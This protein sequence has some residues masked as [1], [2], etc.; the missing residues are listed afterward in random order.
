MTIEFIT[1]LLPY[2]SGMTLR[3]FDEDIDSRKREGRSF[4]MD[5]DEIMWMRFLEAVKVERERRKVNE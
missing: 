1:P 3:C 2:L 4:G 5:C